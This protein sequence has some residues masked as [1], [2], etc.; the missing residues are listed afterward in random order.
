MNSRTRPAFSPEEVAVEA[1]V[2]TRG[3]TTAIIRCKVVSEAAVLG[4]KARVQAVVNP[5]WTTSRWV[6]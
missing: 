5:I 3:S 2:A 1:S 4:P 6:L